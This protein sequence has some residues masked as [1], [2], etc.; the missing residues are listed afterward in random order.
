MS[1]VAP[2]PTTLAIVG[3]TGSNGRLAVA[4]ALDHGLQVR[5]VNRSTRRAR[6]VLGGHLDDPNLTLHEADATDA[7]QLAP[8]VDGVDAVVLAHGNDAE[9]E[10]NYRVIATAVETLPAGTPVSLMSA[11]A[12]TQDIPAFSEILEWRRRGERLLRASALRHTI[13]RPGWFDGHSPGDDRPEF[14]QGDATPLSAMRGV[15]R[16]HIA[17]ALVEA[18]CTPAAAGRTLELFSGPGE[19]VDDWPEAFA[20]LEAD[21]SDRLDGVHDPTGLPLSGEPASVREDL[22]KHGV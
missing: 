9:P 16:R 19:P 2:P 17:A 12:V 8:V 11:I 10:S 18:V 15:R 6:R 4:H 20:T 14:E 5:A 1:N 7:R 3:A 22:R 13:I 21:T